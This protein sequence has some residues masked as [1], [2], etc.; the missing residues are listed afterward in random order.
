MQGPLHSE[1]IRGGDRRGP[2]GG[3]CPRPALRSSSCPSSPPSSSSE[4]KR[5]I[6]A[7]SISR[8]RDRRAGRIAGRPGPAS[9]TDLRRGSDQERL[10]QEQLD[11]R[12]DV[13]L[14][15]GIR[16]SRRRRKNDFRTRRLPFPRHNLE[17]HCHARYGPGDRARTQ[18]G[19][20]AETSTPA[21]IR[22]NC[23]S[24]WPRITPRRKSR[25]QN[26]KKRFIRRKRAPGLKEADML[27][28]LGVALQGLQDR[29]VSMSTSLLY[30]AF[31][32][33]G[34]QYVRTTY[35]RGPDDLHHPPGA[36]DLPL[37]GLRVRRRGV[38]RSRRAALPL[39]AH[40]PPRHVPR[41]AHPARRVPRLRGGAPG[42]RHLR[43]PAA[44]LHQG[45]RAVRAGTLPAG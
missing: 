21:S 45:L 8:Q 32:I 2:A 33:R 12:A 22:R 39:P 3:E 27:I 43:R 17:G 40:R 9:L 7:G 23:S 26:R 16:L 4:W 38:A 28:P 42:R 36:R 1:G 25:G 5:G 20:Q 19:D 24:S 29:E 41:P 10:P 18:P 35:T 15:R 11:G 31:G 14:L 13:P 30:H 6:S 37:L 34:Y 44:E